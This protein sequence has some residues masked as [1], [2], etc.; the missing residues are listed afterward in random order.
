MTHQREH[1]VSRHSGADLIAGKLHECSP[2]EW[3]RNRPWRSRT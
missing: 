1:G 3:L 2:G